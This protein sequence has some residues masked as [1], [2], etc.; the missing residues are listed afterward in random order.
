MNDLINPIPGEQFSEREIEILKFLAE[1]LSN[2][3]IAQKLFL[4]LET[5]KWYNKQLFS[6]LGV[7]SRT[8]AAVKARESGLLDNEATTKKQKPALIKHNLPVELTSFVGREKEITEIAHLLNRSRLVTLTGAG[9]TGKTR[10]ALRVTGVIAYNYRDGAS[11]VPL[12]TINDPAK[13]ANA[14]AKAVGVIEQPN[15]P[16]EETLSYYFKPK[17]MLLL[18]DNFEH[19]LPAVSLV[20]DL[21]TSAPDLTILATSREGL[22]LSGEHEYL[23][24]PLTLPQDEL[25]VSVVELNR[26]EAVTLFVQR[27]QTAVAHFSL[28]DD[29]APVVAAICRRLDGLP[30]AIELAAARIKLFSPDQLLTRLKSRLELLTTGPRDLPARQRTLRATIEWSYNLLDEVERRLFARLSVFQNGRSLEAA[31]VVC[32]PGLGSDPLTALE[33]LLNKSLLYQEQGPGGGPRFFMLETIYEYA[34][35]KLAE[36]GEEEQIRNRHL[37]YFLSLVEAMEPGF[38]REGQLSLL[39]QTESEM[40]NLRAAFEWAL[41]TNRIEATARLISAIDYYFIYSDGLV[42]GYQWVRHIL[43]QKGDISS[44]YRIRFLL[45]ATR[46]AYYCGQKEQSKSL[47]R[48]GIQLARQEGDRFN[49]AWFLVESP[50]VIF[51]DYEI[52]GRFEEAVQFCEEAIA[53]F[54][55]LDHRPGLAL[56]LT[57][58]AEVNVFSGDYTKAGEIFESVLAIC[59]ETGEMIRQIYMLGNLAFVAYRQG[60]YQ[61]AL[62]LALTSLRRGYEIPLRQVVS[63]SLGFLAGALS[64]LGEPKKAARLLGASAAMMRAMGVPYQQSDQREIELY[65]TEIRAQLDEQTF[66]SAW[67]EGEA[68]SMEEAFALAMETTNK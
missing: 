14:I 6:K 8:Q 68:L 13:V 1:G 19:V 37:E 7:R 57:S 24:P 16:L 27:A 31:E 33:S 44:T 45:A 21:L 61:R 9:G 15:I 40:G 66:I 32:G 29:N 47:L 51:E 59:E 34:R 26:S 48:Q 22:R 5:V 12:A 43:T 23:V 28:N 50:L 49:L 3:E 58:L 54:R 67:A 42:E 46:L 4:S 65:S 2:R 39:G 53:I 41:A 56:A 10:L 62:E 30:L 17:Q 11:Y 35:E 20:T 60:D 36:T 64:K 63:Y 52:Q 38:R 55:E 25:S 18:L